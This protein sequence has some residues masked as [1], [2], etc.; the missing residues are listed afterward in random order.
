MAEKELPMLEDE[1]HVYGGRIAGVEPG[2]I[3]E[4]IGI[5]PGDVLASINGHR[6]RDVIDY[7]F[8]G[9]EEELVLEVVRNGEV[10]RID[11]EREYD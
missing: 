3:A 1:T 7:Q 8:Y 11:V 9:A 2:S 5:E 10:H 6:L 4:E